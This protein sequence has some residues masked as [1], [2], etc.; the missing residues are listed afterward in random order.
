MRR[1]WTPTDKPTNV[2]DSRKNNLYIWNGGSQIYE[3]WPDGDKSWEVISRR[4]SDS[5]AGFIEELKELHPWET[6][7]KVMSYEQVPLLSYSAQEFQ[8]P[9][10]IVKQERVLPQQ[11]SRNL[12]KNYTKETVVQ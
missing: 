12:Q 8:I 4:I 5:K 7:V 3:R 2:I 6:P 1:T 10:W 11:A 9:G